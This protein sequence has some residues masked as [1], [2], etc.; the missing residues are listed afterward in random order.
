MGAKKAD[1]KLTDKEVLI[2]LR[3][4]I[5]GKNASHKNI[6]SEEHL[7]RILANRRLTHLLGRSSRSFGDFLSGETFSSKILAVIDEQLVKL[8]Q[9]GSLSIEQ[10]EVFKTKE[11]PETRKNGKIIKAP[12]ANC[13][14]LLLGQAI[15][16]AYSVADAVEGTKNGSKIVKFDKTFL[17]VLKTTEIIKDVAKES[18]KMSQAEVNANEES[19]AEVDVKNVSSKLAA[20]R[21]LSG[22]ENNLLKAIQE[23][24]LLEKELRRSNI[25]EDT[26][27]AYKEILV[28]KPNKIVRF[29]EES[30]IKPKVKDREPVSKNLRINQPG[31]LTE[32]G[33][34][35]E[36]EL[37]L[38]YLQGQKVNS[39]RPTHR[40]SS[41]RFGVENTSNGVDRF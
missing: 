10:L 34:F 16:R 37:A 15:S 3:E 2:K 9:S 36:K 29:D 39:F 1:I 7:G 11:A 17:K 32:R 24:R 12:D 8:V 38:L 31:S 33:D 20:A 41:F 40:R 27:K 21:D 30:L 13:F 6:I 35:S 5:S 28:K 4:S 25:E 26:K 23:K 22:K 19:Q 14:D 18:V